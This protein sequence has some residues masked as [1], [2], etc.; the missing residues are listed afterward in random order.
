MP[1]TNHPGRKKKVKC[2]GQNPCIHCKVYNYTCTYNQLGSKKAKYILSDLQLKISAYETIL[3]TVFPGL[4]LEKV[5]RLQ[6]GETGSVASIVQEIKDKDE[7]FAV[8]VASF[9][10]ALN[11]SLDT[12]HKSP[13]LTVMPQIVKISLPPLDEALR[14]IHLACDLA[15]LFKFY[16]RLNLI[17][18]VRD[19]YQEAVLETT[20]DSHHNRQLA[21]IYSFLA[22]GAL[23]EDNSNAYNYYNALYL[24]LKKKIVE[25]NDVL[26]IQTLFCLIIFLQCTA[27][28]STC[29]L[30]VGIALRAAF[31]VGLHRKV[32]TGNVIAL[33]NRKR[34]FW[35]IYKIDV[36]MNTVLGLPQI[37]DDQ[38][39]QDL[40]LDLE[41]EYITE[42]GYITPKNP[43][44]DLTTIAILNDHTKLIIILNHIVRNIYPINTDLFYDNAN[45][46]G[47]SNPNFIHQLVL[48]VKLMEA[49]LDQWLEKLPLELSPY[50]SNIPKK[51]YKQN[52]LLKLAYLHVQLA[53]YRP[54]IHLILYKYTQRPLINKESI[55]CGMNC[56]NV[57]IKIVELA[58]EMHA[59]QLLNGAYWF[60]IYPI[61]YL[62]AC[63]VYYIHENSGPETNTNV[64]QITRF[65]EKGKNVL[66]DLKNSSMAAA[67]TYQT[68]NVM[69]EQLNRRT[70]KFHSNHERYFEDENPPL[71]TVLESEEH[72]VTNPQPSFQLDLNYLNSPGLNDYNTSSPPADQKYYSSMID[73]LDMNVFGRF[74]PP[75][76]LESKSN[77]SHF[78]KQMTRNDLNLGAPGVPMTGNYSSN[79]GF[80]T[81]NFDLGVTTP[82]EATENAMF[83]NND[84][85]F[86][87]DSSK[88]GM[89]SSGTPTPNANV[90][91]TLDNF[92]STD[93]TIPEETTQPE[94]SDSKPTEKAQTEP[95]LLE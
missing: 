20:S 4:D 52:R 62:V 40:P 37:L 53:L 59:H 1:N 14:L 17:K 42:T 26:N 66:V 75:Y 65:A 72:V 77:N 89:I 27:N 47:P 49:E 80:S 28:L 56:I 61:F 86:P 23:L 18:I 39:D 50:N 32:E 87:V 35:L 70:K 84:D 83:F 38:I 45:N 43:N 6:E 78:A 5:A 67:R 71:G 16:N 58:V 44:R 69:F 36:Y 64:Q 54:F 57:A 10:A 73:K 34:L 88:L 12:D 90:A 94:T 13:L 74:L 92:W 25:T 30:F 9:S 21:F 63:L 24:L 7:L 33:E 31:R 48:K 91:S 2:D 68:L 8:G 85:N 76:M 19:F 82:N 11:D 41:D 22:I 3:A 95:N 51:Y 93:V 60:S 81:P 79:T 15:F 46:P 29:Y 55:K